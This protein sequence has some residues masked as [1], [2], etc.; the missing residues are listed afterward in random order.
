[1]LWNSVVGKDDLVLYIG[2]FYDSV[3]FSGDGAVA[4]L[5]ELVGRLNGRIVLIKGN[6]DKL[7]DTVNRKSLHLL[8]AP[9]WPRK[10]FSHI[11]CKS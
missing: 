10:A 3:P 1:M 8:H 11:A 6:H 2:D 7:G 4:D 5:M 9:L